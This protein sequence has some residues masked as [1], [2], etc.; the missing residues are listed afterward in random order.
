MIRLS[1]EDLAKMTAFQNK[2]LGKKKHKI[3]PYKHPILYQ[4]QRYAMG[5]DCMRVLITGTN[6]YSDNYYSYNDDNVQK[7]IL[8]AIKHKV[9]YNMLNHMAH[10]FNYIL[11]DNMANAYGSDTITVDQ[12]KEYHV[13]EA[14]D[15]LNVCQLIK[16]LNVR[17]SMLNINVGNC[18]KHKPI[19]IN[20]EYEENFELNA[21]ISTWEVG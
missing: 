11:I 4:A 1:D 18:G 9:N 2:Y 3:Y 16:G 20:V 14:R 5:D 8:F 10:D 15:V 7:T 6:A 17:H 12:C 13:V 19:L 21:L